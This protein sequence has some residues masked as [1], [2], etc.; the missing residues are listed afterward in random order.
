MSHPGTGYGFPSFVH[1]ELRDAVSCP[2]KWKQTAGE[3]K[4]EPLPALRMKGT[5]SHRSFLM[6]AT[7]AQNVGHRESLGTVS[8]SL[9]AG[10]VPSRDL[11]Y[12]PMMTFFGSMG[13]IPR[14][15]RT[16]S[17]RISSAE[18]EMGRSIARR[19]ST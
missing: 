16:F 7:I 11:A 4:N 12:C 2:S 1:L 19:V 17:S 14:R 6:C 8:S 18:N 9:Y 15:T 5:P 10:L 13:S 3:A